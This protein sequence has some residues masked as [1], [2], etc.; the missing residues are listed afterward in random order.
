MDLISTF[1]LFAYPVG[2][3]GLVR[4]EERMDEVCEALRRNCL[5][6]GHA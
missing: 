3:T 5:Q 6:K 4:E 2:S 1:K